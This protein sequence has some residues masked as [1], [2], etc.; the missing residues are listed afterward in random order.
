M[1]YIDKFEWSLN[2]DVNFQENILEII[3][4][5]AMTGHCF[6]LEQDVIRWKLFIKTMKLY[7]K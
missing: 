5:S 3:T 1:I 2:L 6:H 4:P 7:L